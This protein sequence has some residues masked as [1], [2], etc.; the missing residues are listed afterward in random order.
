VKFNTDEIIKVKTGKRLSRNYKGYKGTFASLIY[1][2]VHKNALPG[3]H[4]KDLILS[5]EQKDKILL[6]TFSDN[7]PDEVLIN[8]MDIALSNFSAF[9]VKD[10]KAHFTIS[11]NND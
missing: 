2:C 6:I 8:M 9:P 7:H 3:F 10:G 11:I 4:E 5:A 1:S